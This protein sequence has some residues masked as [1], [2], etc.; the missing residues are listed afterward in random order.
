V[1]VTC[2]AGDGYRLHLRGQ[3]PWSDFSGV[4]AASTLGRFKRLD[5]LGLDAE[6]QDGE[7]HLRTT[8]AESIIQFPACLARRGTL[9]LKVGT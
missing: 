9:T 4:T 8:T 6:V 1:R 2:H 7:L 5:T 3:L